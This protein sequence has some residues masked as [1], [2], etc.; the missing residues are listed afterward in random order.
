MKEQFMQKALEYLQSTEAFLQKEV[1]IYITEY[2]NWHMYSSIIWGSIFLLPLFFSIWV[3]YKG[4]TAKYDQELLICLGFLLLLIGV[5][6]VCANVSN[7]VQI[8]VA[9]RVYLIESITAN[10]PK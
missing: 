10:L 8:K 3:M 6:G 2:L 4:I 5:C 9:P 7:I 1:P